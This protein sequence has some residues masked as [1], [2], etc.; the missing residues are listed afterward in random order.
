MHSVWITSLETSYYLKLHEEI[1]DTDID[2]FCFTIKK[3]KMKD[4]SFL[5]NEEQHRLLMCVRIAHAL[6][7]GEVVIDLT[8]HHIL[9]T[10]E[11][12]DIR[13]Y[14]FRSIEA[15]EAFL[16]QTLEKKFESRNRNLQI[17]IR[18]EVISI[19]NES[20]RTGEKMILRSRM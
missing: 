3:K 4:N 18:S 15:L 11:K 7:L 2:A 14:T 8:T 12:K 10:L 20:M 13:T 19:R 16:E 1:K 6:D 9:F 17:S 5:L